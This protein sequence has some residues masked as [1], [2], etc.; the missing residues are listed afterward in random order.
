MEI[1]SPCN[2][3][4]YRMSSVSHVT[5]RFGPSAVFNYSILIFWGICFNGNVSIFSFV[6]RW[7]E[8]QAEWWPIPQSVS[9]F[10]ALLW[11]YHR[12]SE[13]FF[14]F[15]FFVCLFVCFLFFFFLAVWLQIAIQHSFA[16]FLYNIP[17][18]VVLWCFTDNVE[19]PSRTERELFAHSSLPP[20]E[21]TLV[22][23]CFV[24]LHAKPLL[25]WEQILSV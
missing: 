15:F 10:Y 18:Y 21:I 5:K 9:K 23:S 25:K 22:T 20:M 13:G 8:P 11:T 6:R 3:R 7:V 17:A 24:L 4:N 2:G 19:N 14:F 12:P 16:L 1:I